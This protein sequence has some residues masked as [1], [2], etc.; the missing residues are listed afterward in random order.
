MYLK[1]KLVHF[2][3]IPVLLYF[4]ANMF[5]IHADKENAG[6]VNIASRHV[7]AGPLA[8]PIGKTFQTSQPA[9]TPVRKALGDVNRMLSKTP[10]TSKQQPLKETNQ[11]PSL[12]KPPQPASVQPKQKQVLT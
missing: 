3:T 11:V 12:L 6:R 9:A 4:P 7:A 1:Q 10:A 5:S 2:K 8:A